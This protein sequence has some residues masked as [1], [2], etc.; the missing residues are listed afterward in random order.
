MHKLYSLP[1][2]I[3]WLIA[4][5]MFFIGG[6]PIGLILSYAFFSSKIY[7]LLILPF[8]FS[9]AVFSGTPIF[10]LTGVYKYYSPMTLVTRNKDTIEIHNGTS[11]DFLSHFKFSDKGYKWKRRLMTYYLEGIL[12]L[13][14]EL[15]ASNEKDKRIIGTSYFFNIRTAERIGF[16]ISNPSILPKI[17]VTINFLDILFMFS[18]S[19]GKFKIPNIYQLKK[20]EISSNELIEKEDYIM[21]LLHKLNK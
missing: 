4:L 8:A 1:S 18:L 15:K 6:I 10:R 2:P 20:A 17:K 3:K 13:I 7:F 21:A 9:L 11:F 19:E 14:N 5:L 12:N 16:K